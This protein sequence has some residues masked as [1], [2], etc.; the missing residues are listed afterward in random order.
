MIIDV[1]RAKISDPDGVIC[2]FCGAE[3]DWA[4]DCGWFYLESY[5]TIFPD[6]VVPDVLLPSCREC[7]YGEV[8]QMHRDKYGVGER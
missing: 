6:I 8:G 5:L 2:G 7:F 4:D 1:E 3:N